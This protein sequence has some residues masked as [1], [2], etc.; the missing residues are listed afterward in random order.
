[1]NP[2]PAE[3]GRRPDTGPQEQR[4]GMVSPGSYDDTGGLHPQFST[5]VDQ[6]GAMCLTVLNV[7]TGDL[8]VAKD[9]QVGVGPHVVEEGEGAVPPASVIDVDRHRSDAFGRVEV[10]KVVGER[11]PYGNA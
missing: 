4:R 7:Q 9:G 5:L 8:G 10:I 2:V 11:E 1:R 3:F 6:K